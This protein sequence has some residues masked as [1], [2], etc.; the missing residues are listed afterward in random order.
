MDAMALATSWK[1]MLDQGRDVEIPVGTNDFKPTM[2]KGDVAIV[3]KVPWQRL[4]KGD[5]VYCMISNKNVGFYRINNAWVLGGVTCIEVQG[6]RESYSLSEDQVLG[7]VVKVKPQK[8]ALKEIGN[9]SVGD[10]LKRLFSR[11]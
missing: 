1:A 2:S 6:P 9:M 3:Q 11:A 5:P 7:K 10:A 8:E 4:R